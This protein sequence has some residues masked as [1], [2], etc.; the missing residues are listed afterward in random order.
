MRP[1][2]K[3]FP[4]DKIDLEKLWRLVAEK[5]PGRLVTVRDKSGQANSEKRKSA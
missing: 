5:P 2:K 3:Q 1:G 4:S